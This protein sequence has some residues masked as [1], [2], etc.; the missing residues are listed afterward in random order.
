M[1]KILFN[2]DGYRVTSYHTDIHTDIPIEAIQVSDEVQELY[3]TNEYK[4]DLI[5]GLPIKIELPVSQI[6]Q[7]TLEERIA[8]VE[9]VIINLL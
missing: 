4:R 1:Y 2:E 5:T 8:A 3:A 9:D 7:P 6:V